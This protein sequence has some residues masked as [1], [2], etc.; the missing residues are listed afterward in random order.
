[1][2]IRDSLWTRVQGG[3][4]R[5]LSGTTLAELVEFS[6]QSATKRAAVIGS[7]A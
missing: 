7:A 3:V 6:D 5:A 4:T 2:C 1:M